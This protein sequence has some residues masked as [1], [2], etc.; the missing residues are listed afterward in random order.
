MTSG[1][2]PGGP[3]P[4]DRPAPADRSAP[5]DRPAHAV[6]A[7]GSNLGDRWALLRGAVRSLDKLLG[8]SACSPVYETAPVGGPEQD[9]YLNAVVLTA[10]APPRELLAAARAA[11]EQALRVRTVR[12]GPRTLD[13]DV[14]AL[15]MRRSDDPEILLPHPRAHLRAFVCVPWLDV[16][17]DAVLPGHGRVADLVARMSRDG[18][19]AGLRRGASMLLDEGGT[20][21]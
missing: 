4:A 18:E 14:I 20:A 17:P 10:P 19:L 16:E 1:G 3:V 13:V 8:V 11:E 12:W 6:L 15:G 7:L 5:A 9:D 2:A 21:G